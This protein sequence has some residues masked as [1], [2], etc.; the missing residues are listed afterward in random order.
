MMGTQGLELINFINPEL[1][2]K[3]VAKGSRSGSRRSRKVGSSNFTVESINSD[4]G[5]KKVDETSVSYTEK[6]GVAVLGRRFS[7]GIHVPIKKRRFD[8]PASSLSPRSSSPSVD[9]QES[10][11]SSKRRRKASN[12]SATSKFTQKT[13]GS[14]YKFDFNDDFS[15]IE[16]LAAVACNNSIFNDLDIDE[17]SSLGKES[18]QEAIGTS[19]VDSSNVLVNNDGGSSLRKVSIQEAIGTSAVDSPSVLVN[20][21]GIEAPSLED[22]AAVTHNHLDS[23]A[24]EGSPSTRNEKL[25]FDLNVPW[26][27][28]DSVTVD[29]G[30]NAEESCEIQRQEGF[31][32]NTTNRMI[33]SD[34]T[35]NH[36]VSGDMKCIPV[37]T[38]G[39]KEESESVVSGQDGN[40]DEH[41]PSQHADSK[42]NLTSDSAD[43]K[44][45]S[46]IVGTDASLHISSCPGFPD[47]S[48]DVSVCGLENKP[49][50]DVSS[51]DVQPGKDMCS[52][53]G[54]VKACNI[55][56]SSLKQNSN[57][58][59]HETPGFL[60]WGKSIQDKTCLV[61]C[62]QTAPISLG[63][64]P[65]NQAE[66]SGSHQ[67]VPSSRDVSVSTVPTAG[68]QLVAVGDVKGQCDET[69]A[70]NYAEDD[71]SSHS[72][73]AG[74]MQKSLADSTVTTREATSVHGN[75]DTDGLVK[76]VEN[77][78]DDSF[79]SDVY[80]VDKN[81]MVCT[82]NV[83]ELQAGYDSQFEDGELRESDAPNFWDEN[84]EDGEVEH[85]DYG[86][87]YEDDRL[88]GL[89]NELEVRVERATSPGFDN[90][91][92]KLEHDGGVDAPRDVSLSPMNKAS[93][94]LANKDFPPELF[95]S[96][97]SNR[98]F[99]SR[100]EGSNAVHR[101]DGMPRNRSDSSYLCS[102]DGREIVS[103]NFMRRDRPASHM[104]GRSPEGRHF[105][106]PS[107]VGWASERRHSPVYRGTCTS[108]PHRPK[109]GSIENRGY[110]MASNHTDSEIAGF[111][112]LDNR[113]RRPFINPSSKGV[114]ERINRRR[115]P[116]YR[117]NG[118]STPTGMLPVRDNSSI[119]GRYRG[120][121]RGAGRGTREQYHGPLEDN[122]EYS[123]RF[124][125]RLARRERS[126][127]PMNRGRPHYRSRSRSRS[128]ISF[129]PPRERNEGSRLRSRSP[130]FRCDTR[131]D[132]ARGPF[133]KRFPAEFDEE[134][135]PQ[136]RRR[137]QPQR[138]PRWFDD[139]NGASDNFRGRKSPSDTFRPSQRFGSAR[140]GHNRLGSDD[141]FRQFGPRKFIDGGGGPRG[142]GY[143]CS[144]DDRRQR[145]NNRIEMVPRVRR[146]ETDGV[147]R[148]DGVVRRC[149][150]NEEDSLAPIG[151]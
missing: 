38:Y 147:V 42:Q 80:Q 31:E 133:H 14:D 83:T 144:D 20:K 69:S 46:H 135:V 23:K 100:F 107:A 110:V 16:V 81:Q 71:S 108:G 141:Q 116:G 106:D 88:S 72:G 126:M 137:Y 65:G 30:A 89:G 77:P 45:S 90:C 99:M 129:F 13:S 33:V 136:N 22:T 112:G 76:V 105:V 109:G 138:Q 64:V 49:I 70:V 39:L 59:H 63:V 60:G 6:L 104:R 73:S 1:T 67:C 82:K 130:D 74:L 91:S 50:S 85:V 79:E 56:S 44:A 143:E 28:S 18:I 32:C 115:S 61:S 113:P 7:D 94:L 34:S 35:G 103:K 8:L 66:D 93:D 24:S 132:R 134:F 25:H 15:G 87:D 78:S 111:A 118:Y 117:D 123:N 75:C 149:W 52:G 53:S 48:R 51:V 19:A 58:D 2:W 122:N 17:G 68:G 11:S 124:A 114:Y 119:R 10:N 95:G 47:E 145:S 120:F 150:Y 55:S 131:V 12:S 62:Q 139:R 27:Q 102:R 41:V 54:K 21:D 125:P 96:R 148:P 151:Q 37:G 29:S 146:Y 5:T 84:G 40:H 140:S 121:V 26:E 86:S 128:P 97:T 127:S 101:N 4:D 9:V 142:G 57:S 43:A 98:E 36:H 3:T 92:R